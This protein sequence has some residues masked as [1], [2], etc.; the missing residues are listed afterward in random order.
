M[1]GSNDAIGNYK[2][3]KTTLSGINNERFEGRGF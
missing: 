1:M 3:Y 2:F